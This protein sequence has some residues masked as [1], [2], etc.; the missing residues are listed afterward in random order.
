MDMDNPKR[1]QRLYWE[2]F[3]GIVSERRCSFRMAVTQYRDRGYPLFQDLDTP[4]V[5]TQGILPSQ[6]AGVL[7]LP[8]C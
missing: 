1:H 8:G 5:K 2:I 3:L 6:G 4:P 7:H